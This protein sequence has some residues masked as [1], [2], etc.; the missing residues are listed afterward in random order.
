MEL[1]MINDLYALTKSEEET[2]KVSKY[3]SFDFS[4]PSGNNNIINI[5]IIIIIINTNTKRG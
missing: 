4:L 2:L 3:I 1:H 5:I